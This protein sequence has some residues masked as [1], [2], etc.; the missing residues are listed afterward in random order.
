MFKTTANY[1]LGF[2]LIVLSIM[3]FIDGNTTLTILC[4]VLAYE[5]MKD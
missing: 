4:S 2:L 3:E 5:V 1:L